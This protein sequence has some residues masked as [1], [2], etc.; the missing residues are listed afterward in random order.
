[1]HMLRSDRVRD[2]RRELNI[3][4]IDLAKMIG[5]RQAQISR[6]ENYETQPTLENLY[7]LANALKT[8]PDYLL[9]KSDSPDIQLPENL[10][11][12][13]RTSQR[14]RIRVLGRISAGGDQSIAIAAEDVMGFIETEKQADF[15]LQV[16]GDS[17]EPRLF[18][19]DVVLVQKT[20]IDELLN[21]DMVVVIINQDEGLVKRYYY[22][23][24]RVHLQSDNSRYPPRM[25]T[26]EEI[27]IEC[28]I[29]GRV[30]EIRAY[31]RGGL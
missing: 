16:R 29:V 22:T 31:P 28:H 9:G 17:M 11:H 5:V 4:Q 7:A 21:G 19:G 27:G 24:S 14:Y 30:I 26:R 18:E 23:D 8:T 6:Y 1:M 13:D 15:A 3:S 25:F 20:P 12:F 2:R 10:S